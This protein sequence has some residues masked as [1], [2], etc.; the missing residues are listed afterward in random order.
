MQD[1]NKLGLIL[2][3][4]VW[5]LFVVSIQGYFKI[6]LNQVTIE[7]AFMSLLFGTVALVLFMNF[8]NKLSDKM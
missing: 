1:E 5:L 7:T 8:A 2:I 6:S 4:S 3:T